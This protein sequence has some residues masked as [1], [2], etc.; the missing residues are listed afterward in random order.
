MRLSFESNIRAVERDLSDA[1]RNQVPFATSMALSETAADVRDAETARLDR[2]I[3]RPTPFTRRAYGMRRATKRRLEARVFVKPIQARYLKTL[4]GGLVRTPRRRALVTPAK[5]RKNKYGN[6]AR[7]AVPNALAKPNVF[8][9]TPKGRAGV[10]GIY[11]R[12][13]GKLVKLASYV[14][15]ARYAPQLNFERSAARLAR[16]AFPANFERALIKAFA[17]RRR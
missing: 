2:V 6:M 16:A 9:G 8:S 17:S 1:A 13:R 14:R 3:D 4:E 11:Q 15:R 10:P 12:R 5:I 7:R